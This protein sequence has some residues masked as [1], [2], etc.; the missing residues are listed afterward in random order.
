MGLIDQNVPTNVF[1]RL[2]VAQSFENLLRF[3]HWNVLYIAG[4]TSQ[5][6]KRARCPD[7]I[8]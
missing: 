1:I 8:D 2:Y 3:S 6:E 4:V 7:Q 5:V